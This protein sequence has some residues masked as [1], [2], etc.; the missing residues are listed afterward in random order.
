MIRTLNQSKDQVVTINFKVDA[1]T[2]T[3]KISDSGRGFDVDAAQVEVSEGRRQG[4]GKRGWGLKIIEELM[5]EVRVESGW[6]QG[7]AITLVKH[8]YG[9]GC[10]EI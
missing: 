5:D 4:D 3:V 6:I 1:D 9:E 7:T 10:P 8:R 2:L